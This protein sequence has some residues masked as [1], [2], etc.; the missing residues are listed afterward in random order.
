M[1][2]QTPGQAQP[3]DLDERGVAEYLAQHPRFFERHHRLLS[4]LWLPHESGGAVSLVERQI[5]L[6]RE[7]NRSL[8][9]RL[10]SLTRNAQDNERLQSRLQ[11][12]S[13]DLMGLGEVAAVQEVLKRSL[14][15]DFRADA[16]ALRLFLPAEEHPEVPA[17]LR[18]PVAGP[19]RDA[20]SVVLEAGRPSCGAADPEQLAPLFGEAAQQL[21]S[22]ALVPL[23]RGARRGLLA[24]GSRDPQ[25]FHARVGTLFLDHLG[26]LVSGA[27]KHYLG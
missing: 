8:Q 10:D 17:E 26:A 2:K 1:S 6:L 25:R 5:S 12:L 23:G 22:V 3:E 19:E 11:R 24:V 27:L 7:E 21:G 13:V 18:F 15:V 9:R 14:H 16:F 20:Y 4:G